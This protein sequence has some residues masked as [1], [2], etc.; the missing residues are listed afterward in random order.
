[1]NPYAQGGW[2]NSFNHNAV[3]NPSSGASPLY[4]VLPYVTSPTLTFLTFNFSSLDGTILDSEIVGPHSRTYFRVSTDSTTSGFSVI[5]NA[6][7]ESVA[8]IEWKT[9]PVIEIRGIVSKRTSAQWLPLSPDKT[10]RMMS[11]RGRNFRWTPSNGCINLYNTSFHNPELF[12]RISQGQNGIVL[13]I[14]TEA[15]QIGLLEVFVVSALLMMSGRSI[16]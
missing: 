8:L 10:Y 14:T 3:N 6:K 7:Q 15:I 1:M 5:Q 4:G 16:D 2:S 11:A 13:E 9:H 12:G